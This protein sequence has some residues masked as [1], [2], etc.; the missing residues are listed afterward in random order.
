M[1]DAAW[2]ARMVQA[3]TEAPRGRSGS[4]PCTRASTQ[5]RLV[6]RPSCG[7]ARRMC[8]RL[9]GWW[10]ARSCWA[11]GAAPDSVVG[12]FENGSLADGTSV[13]A[14]GAFRSVIIHS[15]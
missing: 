9:A 4:G 10:A 11:E 7:S 13:A 1:N 3:R 12:Q 6:D 15:L 14:R 2:W 8:G 5:P